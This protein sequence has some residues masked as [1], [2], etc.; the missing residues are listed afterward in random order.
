MHKRIVIAALAAMLIAGFSTIQ[1]QQIVSGSRTERDNGPVITMAD[2]REVKVATAGGSVSLVRGARAA[3]LERG[4]LLVIQFTG[5]PNDA[6]LAQLEKEGVRLHGYLGDNAYWASAPAANRLRGH[7]WLRSIARPSAAERISPLLAT[8]IV[9][10]GEDAPLRVIVSLTPGTSRAELLMELARIGAPLAEPQMLYADRAALELPAA[11]AIAL[12]GSDLVLAVEPGDLPKAPH[13][14]VSSN[15]IGSTAARNTYGLSGAGVNVGVWDGG[16]VFNHKELKGRLTVVEKD[17]DISDHATH[18]SGTIAGAGKNKAAMGMAPKARIYSYDYG[19]DVATEMANAV[20]NYSIIL[21]NNSWG[22]LVGWHWQNFSGYGWWPAWYGKDNFGAYTSDSSALDAVVQNKNLIILFS[23]GNDRDD[24]CGADYYVDF[25]RG[26]YFYSSGSRYYEK[27]GPYMTVGPTGSAKNVITVGATQG[28]KTM[29]EFS[30]WGPTK[31]GRIKPEVSAPGVN[32]FSSVSDNQYDSY[33]GTSMA[34]P[35]TTGSAALLVEQWRMYPA[36]S[37]SAAGDPTPALMR[38]IL[39]ATATD[40]GV[41]GPDY[42]FGFGVINTA[43][44][45]NLIY[46]NTMSTQVIQ[47]SV[48]RGKTVSYSL[49]LPGG[50]K[51]ARV[52]LAWIDPPGGTLVND[53]DL[54]VYS[55]SGKKN[56]PWLLNPASV[57]AKAVRGVNFRDNIELVTIVKPE[58]GDTWRIDVK[59]TRLGSGKKQNFALVLWVE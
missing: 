18:V 55:P 23:A 34:C 24:E 39:V 16:Q 51:F 44:A 54:N 11:L 38:A 49:T 7:S 30:S 20:N 46:Y 59:A 19:E 48:K 42:S 32:V 12:A 31:D 28:A 35:V 29:A 40:I 17:Y 45:S 56:Q 15:T 27:D 1:A 26:G 25:T 36:A 57:S 41:A 8:R 58:A 13:N 14:A 3:D 47:S 53:L 43:K 9:A 22:Y 6:M 33:S 5:E 2:D 52:C 21:S 4:G 37:P 50:L 10:L